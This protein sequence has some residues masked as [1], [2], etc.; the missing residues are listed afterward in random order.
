M[1]RPYQIKAMTVAV[2]AGAQA[3]SLNA[4]GNHNQARIAITRQTHSKVKRTPDGH[5]RI[6]QPT[7]RLAPASSQPNQCKRRRFTTGMLSIGSKAAASQSFQ[8]TV[9]VALAACGDNAHRETS[10]RN[11][12]RTDA[13]DTSSG[14]AEETSGSRLISA[15]R[16]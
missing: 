16:E 15:D 7:A 12:E 8:S 9:P 4:P 1:A 13:H 11:H 6:L 14:P 10:P 3:V 5:P 2:H